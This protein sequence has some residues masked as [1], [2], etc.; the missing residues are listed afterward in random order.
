MPNSCPDERLETASTALEMLYLMPKSLAQLVYYQERNHS[1]PDDSGPRRPAAISRRRQQPGFP[2]WVIRGGS[3]AL[4][5]RATSTSASMGH[6]HYAARTPVGRPIVQPVV[7]PAGRR[8]RSEQRAAASHASRAGRAGVD[9]RADTPP[10]P[11]PDSHSSRPSGRL[12]LRW[13]RPAQSFPLSSSPR[14]GGVGGEA[15]PTSRRGGIRRTVYALIAL[16]VVQTLFLAAIAWGLTSPTFQARYVQIQGTNDSTLLAAIQRLPLRGCNIFR[17]DL[18]SRIQMVEA[19]PAI[20]HADIHT[21]YPNGLLV[22]VTPRR[23][24]LL[25]QT[26]GQPLVV[27]DDGTV[28]GS[29][30]SDPTYA[31]LALLPISDP[32]AAAFSGQIPHPGRQIPATEAEMAGQLRTGITGMLGDGW[33]LQWTADAGFV[34]LDGRGTQI[35][36][37]APADATQTLSSYPDLAELAAT[38]TAADVDRGVSA[39]LQILQAL[40]SQLT[41]TGQRAV[42]ID[43]RWALHP[44]YRLAN[45]A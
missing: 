16:L 34:A 28:L 1:M 8:A 5:S 13:K 2:F 31:K 43:L 44:Y 26:D 35:L 22:V 21:I 39:Q 36:F 45:G 23:P 9:L 37:G 17:C 10:A 25:W 4:N 33:T 30:A 20:T 41:Q 18:A 29:L 42:L 19:L 32:S 40:Q 24:M 12:T 3:R 6:A 27:A 11:R 14:G 7:V 38:P 15:L